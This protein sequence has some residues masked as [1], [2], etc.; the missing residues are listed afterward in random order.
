MHLN[1]FNAPQSLNKHIFIYVFIS[2]IKIVQSIFPHLISAGI[3]FILFTKVAVDSLA[4]R[5]QCKQT[6]KQRP[7]WGKKKK[8]TPFSQ[9]SKSILNIILCHLLSKI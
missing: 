9:N 5:W 6:T 7:V 1:A 2:V 4:A 3:F 8:C